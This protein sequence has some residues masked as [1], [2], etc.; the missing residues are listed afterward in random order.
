M[1]AIQKPSALTDKDIKTLEQA[2]IIP[3]GCP[4]DQVAVFAAVCREKGLSAFSKEIYLVGYGGKYSTIVGVNGLLKIAAETGQLAGIDDA[5][6]DLMPDGSYKTAA[7]L[8]MEGKKPISATVTVY[9]AVGGMRC[10]FQHTAV[11]SEFSSDQNKWQSMP[12]QMIAKVATAHAIR[13]GFSD[14]TTGLFVDAELDAIADVTPDAVAAKTKQQEEL[15]RNKQYL[16]GRL[17][18]CRMDDE[19]ENKFRLEIIGAASRGELL[20]ISQRM[21]EYAYQDETAISAKQR[22][23]QVA[24]R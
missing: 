2:G 7:Q 21:K 17:E 14:R 19:T 20:A 18:E 4:V 10:P 22:I 1:T 16:F 23:K 9:R 3:K 6:Y 24:Q 8:K 5:K 11:F 13:K 12:Y 15:D